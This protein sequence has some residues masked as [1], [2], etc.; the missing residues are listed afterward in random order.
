MKKY[1]VL[2]IK[3]LITAGLIWLLLSKVDFS[4]LLTEIKNI[5]KT[6]FVLA[7]IAMFG[8]WLFNTWRWEALLKIFNFHIATFKLFLYNLVSIFYSFVLPGGKITSDVVRAYQVARDHNGLKSEKHQLFLLTF[9]DRGLG[10][11]S[12]MFFVSFYFILGHPA[13]YAFGEN[14]A[15]VGIILI[16]GTIF[17][18]GLIFT[19]YFDGVL[20]FFLKI[21]LRSWQKLIQLLYDSLRARAHGRRKLFES[22]ALSLGSVFMGGLSAY[23]ISTALGIDANYWT[24]TFFYSLAVILIVIPVTV[25]GI[26]L[27][28]G[29]FAYLLVQIGTAPEK[30]LASSL[31]SLAVLMTMAVAGGL[32]EFYDHFLRPKPVATPSEETPSV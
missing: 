19:G 25:A 2:L 18:L 9:I 3:I 7:V 10:V 12:L 13:I 6:A 30:A 22:F 28:E 17:G 26:G 27:R 5:D 21:P 16:A 8:G 31:L 20:K 11:L 14:T 15:L 29:G 23:F 24:M 4:K 32:V 1:I